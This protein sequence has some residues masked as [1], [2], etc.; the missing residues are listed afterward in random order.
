MGKGVFFNGLINLIFPEGLTLGNNVHIGRNAHFDCR[1]GVVIGDHTHISRNVTIYSTNHDYEGDL[2]PYNSDLIRKSVIIGKGVWIGMNVSILPGVKIGDGAII[3]MGS[4][5]SK[6]VPA[7]KIAVSNQQRL[8]AKRNMEKFEEKLKTSKIGGKSGFP[9]TSSWISEKCTI[10][11]K[12]DSRPQDIVFLFS[13]SSFK[14]L[15]F[16]NSENKIDF[17]KE[18]FSTQLSILCVQYLKGLITKIEAEANL[19]KLYSSISVADSNKKFIEFHSTSIPLMPLFIEVF[20]DAKFVWLVEHPRLIIE[21]YPKQNK[22]Y[23]NRNDIYESYCEINDLGNSEMRNSNNSIEDL[24][25]WKR[26]NLLMYNSFQQ[27]PPS[28][29]F[30]LKSFQNSDFKEFS[31]FLKIDVII[32]GIDLKKNKAQFEGNDTLDLKEFN[33]IYDQFVDSEK[34][35]S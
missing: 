8:I 32:T 10:Q 30:I 35:P 19:K 7:G 27:I 29:R 9:V 24:Q 14:S 2:I 5:I 6:D 28:H 17:H 25:L 15:K 18:I 12:Y 11:E 20:P 21:K 22:K 31:K 26:W 16:V 34:L 33:E 3:A 4:V 1:G 23:L 13:T